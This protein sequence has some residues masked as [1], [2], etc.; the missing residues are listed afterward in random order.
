MIKITFSYLIIYKL[1]ILHI[2]RM[3]KHTHTHYQSRGA[4][5]RVYVYM[6]IDYT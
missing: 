5:Q 4:E 6:K 2:N 3:Y 1:F